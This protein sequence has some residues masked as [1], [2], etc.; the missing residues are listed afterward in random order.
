[1]GVSCNELESYGKETKE[2][3][4]RIWKLFSNLGVKTTSTMTTVQS[5]KEGRKPGMLL[6]RV[7]A[8]ER[9]W[10]LSLASQ[11]RKTHRCSQRGFQ[12][13]LDGYGGEVLRFT[14][15]HHFYPPKAGA[16]L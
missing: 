2:S 15:N 11:E 8:G 4:E 7:N 12:V 1:M 13:S 6:R 10:G 5:I 9:P 14:V 16:C 3:L